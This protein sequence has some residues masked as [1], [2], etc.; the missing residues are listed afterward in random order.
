M[1]MPLVR[2]SFSYFSQSVINP[3]KAFSLLKQ[4]RTFSVGFFLNTLKWVLC[5]FYVYY[6]FKT[7]Q[8]LFIEPW[9]NIPAD[10]Y[11]YYELFFYIPYGIL[12][13]VFTAGLVQTLA[14]VFGGKETFTST[15]NI[16]GIMIFTPFVFIDTIDA[17]FIILNAGDWNIVFNSITRTI[18][19]VWSGVLL[20]FG[21]KIVHELQTKKSIV[22]ALLIMPLTIFVN[23]FF[24]R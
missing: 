9:L 10:Q 15:L 2:R 13:W 14:S 22:I 20:V 8:I 19:V 4:E 5:E 17:L 1:Q 23:L 12:A 3:R 18:Y 16:V 7:N 6:L 11:R 21:L 24:V